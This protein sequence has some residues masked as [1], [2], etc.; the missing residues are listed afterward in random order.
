MFLFFR[1]SMVRAPDK[2]LDT[3]EEFTQMRIR[4]LVDFFGTEGT[5]EG[6]VRLSLL[7]AGE[8]ILEPPCP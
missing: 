7:I 1:G 3:L 8:L 6:V 2:Q 4:V 5:R